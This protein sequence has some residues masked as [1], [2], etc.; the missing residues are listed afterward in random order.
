MLWYS[1]MQVP[2]FFI[3]ILTIIPII[4]LYKNK[5]VWISFLIFYSYLI[6]FVFIAK[7]HSTFLYARY[8]YPALPFFTILLGIS[9]SF[10]L[11][12]PLF[13]SK[14]KILRIIYF[15]GILLFLGSVFNINNTIYTINTNVMSIENDGRQVISVAYWDYSELLKF[16]EDNNFT[17]NDIIIASELRIKNIIAWHFD[18]DFYENRTVRSF[19]YI[20]YD[21][22]D[23]MYVIEISSLEAIINN[24]SGW[25]VR[26]DGESVPEEIFTQRGEKLELSE[27][28]KNRNI[29]IVYLGKY[30][31]KYEVYKWHKNE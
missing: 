21:L 12:F 13:F 22:A 31:D 26:R 6:F 16:M 24:P 7:P 29:E 17:K 3:F 5:Y 15:L 20:R 28:L 19:N 2:W 23:N 18:M 1:F 10:I 14:D 27:E 8:I 11:K 25:I 4:F 30:S 9:I